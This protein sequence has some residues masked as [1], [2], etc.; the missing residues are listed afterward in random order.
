MATAPVTPYPKFKAFDSNGAPLAG[1]LLYT[2]EIGTTTPKTT[3]SDYDLGTE[4]E[5]PVELDANGEADVFFNG[6]IKFVLKDSDGN[7]LWTLDNISVETVPQNLVAYIPGAEAPTGWSEYTAGRGRVIVGLPFGGTDEGTLGTALTDLQ[8]LTHLHTGPSHTHSQ[9]TGGTTTDD[10][11]N[12]VE[13]VAGALFDD[14]I[15][16]GAG[17]GA[18]KYG[19]RAGVGASGTGDSGTAALSDFFAYIQLMAIKKD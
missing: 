2:Y 6:S 15:Y 11:D 18:T 7:L 10:T 4:N 16:V 3:Y 9:K 19:M 13:A 5:N 1:G 14:E 12:P 8:D 17:G